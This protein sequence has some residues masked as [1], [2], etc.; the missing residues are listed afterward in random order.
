M[1]DTIGSF[2]ALSAGIVLLVFVMRPGTES[3][4]E[5]IFPLRFRAFVT[6]LLEALSFSVILFGILGFPESGMTLILNHLT[7]FIVVL[8]ILMTMFLWAN[9]GPREFS[10]SG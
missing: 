4:L 6:S 7:S 9:I 1:R 5:R 8:G 3:F 10:S 2:V